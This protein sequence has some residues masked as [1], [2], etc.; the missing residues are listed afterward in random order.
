[1]R[2]A[3]RITRHAISPRLAIR[4]FLNI[5][6][7]ASCRLKDLRN[8]ANATLTAIDACH[9]APLTRMEKSQELGPVTHSAD[10]PY[11]LLADFVPSLLTATVVKVLERTSTVD[12][13]CVDKSIPFAW[14]SRR[15]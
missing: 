6:A 15:I 5:S 12:T 4:I 14:L 11:S 2:R 3:V 10:Q 9:E 1:M 8:E 7:L 13:N